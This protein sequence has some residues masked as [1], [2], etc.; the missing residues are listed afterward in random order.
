MMLYTVFENERA[1]KL[2]SIEKKINNILSPYNVALVF[3]P[4][5][6]DFNVSYFVAK[7]L[8]LSVLIVVYGYTKCYFF[9]NIFAYFMTI[10]IVFLFSLKWNIFFLSLKWNIWSQSL[11]A[12]QTIN[13][14]FVGRRWLPVFY[15]K[16]TSD[17]RTKFPPMD[18][19][20]R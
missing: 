9:V 2:R 12:E 13:D 19:F 10:Y 1:S 16:E 3:I 4:Y 18:K 15:T 20:W 14:R 6:P 5:V 11:S 8:K 7:Y 17:Y